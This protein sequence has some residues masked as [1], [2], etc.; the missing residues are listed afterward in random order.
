M[1]LQPNLSHREARVAAAAVVAT[2]FL[3][4]AATIAAASLLILAVSNDPSCSLD[5]AITLRLSQEHGSFAGLRIANRSIGAAELGS[6]SRRV[7]DSRNGVSN[8]LEEELE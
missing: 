5:S 4:S 8:E 6:F 3:P 7:L 1:G 2:F